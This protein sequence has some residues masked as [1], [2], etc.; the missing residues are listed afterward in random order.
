MTLTASFPAGEGDP[1]GTTAAALRRIQA[2]QIVRAANGTPRVGV[3]PLTY[4]PLVTGKAS[5]GYDIGPHVSA[6]ART[7][8]EV[9]YV[10]NDATAD[11]SPVGYEAPTANS[12]IDVI[13]ER[14]ERTSAGDPAN[15]RRFGISQGTPNA[16]PTKPTIPPG[17][18]ELAVAEVKS[19][20]TTTQ[21]VVIT[22]THPYTAMAGGTVP[23]RNAAELAAWAPAD[24][25]QAYRIDTSSYHERVAGA[26]RRRGNSFRM[27]T[28]ARGGMSDGSPFFQVPVEDTSKDTEPAFAYTYSN[29]DGRI[30]LEPGIYQVHATGH[31]GSVATGTTFLQIRGT[32]QGVRARTLPAFNADPVMSASA[33]FRADGSEGLIVEIQKQTGGSSNASGT[34]SIERT[35]NL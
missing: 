22:Q 28:T 23:V 21:T 34:L 31:P 32:S 4:A 26:W 14:I 18:L 13:W 5:K 6:L 1:T 35:G 30:T 9:E 25:A 33:S 7:P 29:T 27:F 19:T 8:G 10:A 2:G 24:G 15:V 3:F 16:N 12:R 11:L 20:D 17:A